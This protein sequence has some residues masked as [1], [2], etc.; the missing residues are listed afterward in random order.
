M[1]TTNHIC[2]ACGRSFLGIGP[3]NYHM[4]SCR[5]GKKRLQ[6]ALSAVH[7]LWQ[8][9]VAAR[10][11]RKLNIHPVEHAKH[12]V[13][14][15][16]LFSDVAQEL[17]DPVGNIYPSV[18][19]ESDVIWQDNLTTRPALNDRR[20]AQESQ[21]P[22]EVTRESRCLSTAP[23]LFLDILPQPPPPL[24]PQMEPCMFFFQ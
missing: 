12:P 9:R 21:V 4:R 24:V 15:D 23:Q 7:Q 5:P 6:V 17:V 10:K 20:A 16:S 19:A 8:D 1:N 14:A 2:D 13:A 11:R 22:D 3:L 18:D